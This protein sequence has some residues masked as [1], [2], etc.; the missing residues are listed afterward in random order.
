MYFFISHE[1]ESTLA[2]EKGILGE[3]YQAVQIAEKLLADA[4]KK[5]QKK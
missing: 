2:N 5:R 4:A 3:L 1:V